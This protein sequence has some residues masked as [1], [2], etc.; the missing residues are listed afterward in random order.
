MSRVGLISSLLFYTGAVIN[1]LFNFSLT[2]HTFYFCY[3][4][5]SLSALF[6][7]APIMT[8]K[9]TVSGYRR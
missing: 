6:I 5:L 8:L 4:C 7:G 9:L 2:L 1:E 3:I